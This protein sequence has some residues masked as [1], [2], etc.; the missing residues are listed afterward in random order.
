ME[1]VGIRVIEGEEDGVELDMLSEEDVLDVVELDVVDMD[2][3]V[4]SGGE[5]K[6]ELEEG[7]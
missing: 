6:T 2:V 3:V 7:S 1:A 4:G 5:V